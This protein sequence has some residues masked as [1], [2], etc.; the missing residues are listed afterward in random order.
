MSLRSEMDA[1]EEWMFSTFA[2]FVIIVYTSIFVFSPEAPTPMKYFGYF[3]AVIAAIFAPVYI[4]TT[5]KML[6]SLDS[7]DDQE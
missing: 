3:T 6:D 1:F 7:E 5:K 2:Y 4:S